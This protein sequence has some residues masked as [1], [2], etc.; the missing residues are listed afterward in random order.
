MK[1]YEDENHVSIKV[2]QKFLGSLLCVTCYADCNVSSTQNLFALGCNNLILLSQTKTEI[3]FA[4][5]CTIANASP[6]LVVGPLVFQISRWT[7]PCRKIL[8]GILT[9]GLDN[10]FRSE[11]D[12]TSLLCLFSI[13]IFFKNNSSF[14][15]NAT[16]DLMWLISYYFAVTGG[17]QWQ[18]FTIYKDPINKI[19]AERTRNSYYWTVLFSKSLWNITWLWNPLSSSLFQQFYLLICVAFWGI[20]ILAMNVKHWDR[21]YRNYSSTY[22]NHLNKCTYFRRNNSIVI[23]KK[24]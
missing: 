12:L 13:S 11:K 4:F 7:K 8:K 21:N 22:I 19:M 5:T 16:K 17:T 24:I 14:L 23:L 20:F 6:A 1:V 3:L 2:Y 15:T 10:T 9:L 18:N